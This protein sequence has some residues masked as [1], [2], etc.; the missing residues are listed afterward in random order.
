MKTKTLLILAGL[1]TTQCMFNSCG[2]D[3]INNQEE[4]SKTSNTINNLNGPVS[5]QNYFANPEPFSGAVN[6]AISTVGTQGASFT[7]T[8]S[9]LNQFYDKAQ[10]P[11]NERATLSQVNQIIDKTI[12]AYQVS[13]DQTV[14]QLPISTVAKS[15]MILINTHSISNLTSDVKFNTLSN[16]EK[17]IINNFN[18]LQRNIELGLILTPS[19]TSKEMGPGAQLGAKIGFAVGVG[20]GF[21]TLNPGALWGGICAGSMIG[22]AIGSLW[23][24]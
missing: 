7:L 13:F 22:G 24:K 9:L 16:N 17:I 5:T 14:Q 2:E 20:I 4:F 6:F 1:A 19:T 12:N 11:V 8:Q 23:D 21:V 3:N 10:I 15:L 18:N